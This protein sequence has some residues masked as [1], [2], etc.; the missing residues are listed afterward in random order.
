MNPTSTKPAQSFGEQ[1]ARFSLYAPFMVIIIGVVANSSHLPS[2]GLVL[3]GI[4]VL[5]V[6]A[7]FV[8]GVVALVSIRRFGRR[9]ILGRAVAGLLLLNGVLLASM[10]YL[11]PS[12]VRAVRAGHL[13]ERMVGRWLLQS[14]PAPVPGSL[15]VTYNKDGTFTIDIVR[16]G[17][18]VGSLSGSWFLSD[19][20]MLAVRIDRVTKGDAS[21]AGRRMG[22]GKVLSA[23]DRQMV[24]RTDKGQE[25]YARQR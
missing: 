11:T 12:I 25:V 2:A 9:R 8:S 18:T 13:R 20:Q 19:Q 14:T 22:M 16:D 1:A 6:V 10:V 17:A 15:T 24:L 7:G 23:D 21:A 5:L 4:N 3:G